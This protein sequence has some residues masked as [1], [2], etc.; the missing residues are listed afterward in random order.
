[1]SCVEITVNILYLTLR[2]FMR[3]ARQD[4]GALLNNDKDSMAAFFGGER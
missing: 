1:M 2:R 4:D 3:G